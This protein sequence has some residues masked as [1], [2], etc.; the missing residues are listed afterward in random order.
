MF[1]GLEKKH[2]RLLNLVLIILL[3]LAAG[4][5]LATLV[6]LHLAG[7]KPSMEAATRQK[8][9]SWRKPPFYAYQSVLTNNLFDPQARNKADGLSLAD[10]SG[11]EGK[12]G[13]TDLTLLGTVTARHS[14]LA[15]FLIRNEE[16]IVRSGG[17]IPGGGILQEVLRDLVRIRDGSGRIYEVTLDGSS[18]SATGSD[19]PAPIPGD[20][21]SDVREVGENRWIIGSQTA[22]NAKDNM[23]EIMKQARLVP[24]GKEGQ[25]EGFRVVMVRPQSLFWNLGLKRGDVIREVNGIS[26]DSA[27]KGLQI[28]QQLREAQ[29]ISLV[30]QRENENLEFEYEVE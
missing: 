18:P 9:L 21:M 5:L 30:L 24:E 12:P 6:G 7:Q 17:E 4:Y 15:V 28:Y 20:S 3:G 16:H 11:Q 27:E 25:I 26:L 23:N 22:Q 8:S 29:K 13:R 2:I 10:G 14:P 19:A 1:F